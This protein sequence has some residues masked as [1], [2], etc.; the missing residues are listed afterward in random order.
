MGGPLAWGLDTYLDEQN[1]LLD[2][3]TQYDIGRLRCHAARDRDPLRS[4]AETARAVT[5]QADP[6]LAALECTDTNSP[7]LV[8]KPPQLVLVARDFDRRTDAALRYLAENSLPITV[9]GVTVYQD[10]EAR[11]FVDI[12]A[13][14]EPDI[15]QSG[16]GD[17]GPS[18]AIVHHIDGR[19]VVVNDLLEAGLIKPDTPLTWTRPRIGETYK[20]RVFSTG[21]IRLDDG[22]TFSSPSLAAREAAG[23]VAYNGWN[24]WKIPDGRTLSELRTELI[25]QHNPDQ[26]QEG[27]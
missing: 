11:R 13:D 4:F 27:S 18:G 14:H 20:A 6:T 3:T 25:E 16:G 15:F 26:G 22:R 17:S 12:D 5:P 8:Q 19:P 2:D 10:Q 1:D 7:L 21:T 9:L 24:A 23:I